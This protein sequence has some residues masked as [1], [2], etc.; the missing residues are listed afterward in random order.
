MRFALPFASA[1]LVFLLLEALVACALFVPV[2][3]VA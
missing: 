1:V 3:S 2:G